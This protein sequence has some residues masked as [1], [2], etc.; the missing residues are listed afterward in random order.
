MEIRPRPRSQG[1]PG[2]R[3]VAAV[4]DRPGGTTFPRPVTLSTSADRS[5]ARPV[6]PVALSRGTNWQGD[7]CR[8]DRRPRLRRGTASWPGS[9]RPSTAASSPTWSPSS[10]ELEQVLYEARGPIDY[11]Y[12]PTGAVLSALTVMRDGNAI[13]V[14]TVGN[15]GLVGHYGF[16]GKTSPHRVIVQVGDGGLRI[17]VAGLAGG[18]RDGR[19]AARTC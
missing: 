8:R 17:A 3:R 9:P 16:G 10:C 2:A 6:P 4:A 12:F 7:R 14:A 15:E 1:R 5:T 11:A 13:E 18:G 19:P